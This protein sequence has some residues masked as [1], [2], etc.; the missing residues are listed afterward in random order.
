MPVFRISSNFFLVQNSGSQ[1]PL[2]SM[3]GMGVPW[4]GQHLNCHRSSNCP[5]R[6]SPYPRATKL[7]PQEFQMSRPW[8][9]LPRSPFFLSLG[10]KSK[11]CVWK[12]V[13]RC[14]HHDENINLPSQTMWSVE[15]PLGQYFIS[16][17]WIHSRLW[18]DWGASLMTAITQPTQPEMTTCIICAVASQSP[19]W[20]FSSSVGSIDNEVC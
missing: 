6:H 8:Q 20:Y 5:A 16:G 11:L 17:L 3:E 4:T 13:C 15:V 9:P 14:D 12:S 19:R 1:D 18:K 7:L 2:V 10:I